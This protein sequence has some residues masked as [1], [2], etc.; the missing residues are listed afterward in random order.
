MKRNSKLLLFLGIVTLNGRT[1]GRVFKNHNAT[2]K[3][4]KSRS[5]WGYGAAGQLTFT[6]LVNKND[7]GYFKNLSLFLAPADRW[8]S[9][10]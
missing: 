5:R 9:W 3:R 1:F 2:Q 8:S 6:F 4:V 10:E 7:D